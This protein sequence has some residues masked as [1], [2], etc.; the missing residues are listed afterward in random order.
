MEKVK[1]KLNII[2]DDAMACFL[3]EQVIHE[4]DGERLVKYLSFYVYFNDSS[5]HAS[6]EFQPNPVL[7]STPLVT[8]RQLG[9]ND[10]SYT[11]EARFTDALTIVK[12]TE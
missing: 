1:G 7:A 9:T 6:M 5:F 4:L 12:L 2:N 8:A 11:F 10:D 3:L